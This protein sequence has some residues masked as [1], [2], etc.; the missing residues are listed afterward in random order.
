M[1]WFRS[2]Q[3]LDQ[4]K[5]GPLQVLREQLVNV[6]KLVLVDI[7]ENPEVLNL[8]LEELVSAIGNIVLQVCLNTFQY[9]YVDA[10]YQPQLIAQEIE[11]CLN[12]VAKSGS[13]PLSDVDAKAAQRTVQEEVFT[14]LNNVSSSTDTRDLI[15]E[16][17]N[18]VMFIVGNAISETF[19]L[20]FNV[21]IEMEPQSV[22]PSDLEEDPAKI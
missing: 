20:S 8:E 9:G 14:I 12:L 6:T 1:T 5:K 10:S 16:V 7:D 11:R 15:K 18:A 13:I 2:C 3:L 21:A 4:K 22:G 19:G 17:A